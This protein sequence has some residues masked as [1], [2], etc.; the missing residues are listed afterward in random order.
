MSTVPLEHPSAMSRT[1]NTACSQAQFTVSGIRVEIG[2][3]FPCLPS[4][5]FGP[6]EREEFKVQ[7]YIHPIRIVG[8][9]SLASVG[10]APPKYLARVENWVIDLDL[11][12]LG[13]LPRDQDSRF[14]KESIPWG[15]G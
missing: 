7:K 12:W 13:I 9:N 15:S 8:T 11:E 4:I 2:Y 10:L 6:S 3:I 1:P 14:A 5:W